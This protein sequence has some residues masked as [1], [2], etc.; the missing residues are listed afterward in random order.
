MTIEA[1]PNIVNSN[2]IQHFDAANTK[3][4]PG[5][6]TT[7]TDLAVGTNNG[8]LTNSPTYTSSG[9]GS[10]FTFAS[11]SSQYISVAGSR[12][13][14]AATFVIW[15][16]RSGNQGNYAGV[17]FSRGGGGNANGVTFRGTSN[18]ISYTWNDAANTY[19]WV[20]GLVVPD[21]TWCMC[22]VSISSSSAT[23]YLFQNS[24]IS[25]ATNTVSHATVTLGALDIARDNFPRYFNGRIGAVML[26]DTNLTQ[27]QLTQ[28]FNA[29]RGRYGI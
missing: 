5:S 4:Y 11:G 19:N 27:A 18:E 21:I 1:G 26:Y 9:S 10:Y 12:T 22:A 17:F 23:A 29:L 2:L 7:W 16:Y 25:S 20:S 13:L 6:G 14:S 8:T 3:S 24:G 15:L 28:N